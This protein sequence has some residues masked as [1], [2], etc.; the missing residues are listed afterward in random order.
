MRVPSALLAF[1]LVIGSLSAREALRREFARPPDSARPWVFAY[2]MDGNVTKEGITAD[3]EA[4]KSGGIGGLTFFDCAL[5]NPKGPHRF[6]SETWHE[7]FQHLM[8]EAA[9]LG[10]EVTL[11]NAAGWAGSGGPWVKPE[12]A[13]QKV[14]IHEQVVEGPRRLSS[15]LPK[16]GGVRHGFYR[17]IAVLA[18]P[19][20]DGA[21]TRR[22]E[23]FD[24]TKSFSGNRDFATVVPWPRHI[25]ARAE[26]PALP[27]GQFVEAGKMVD[28]TGRL[29]SDGTLAWEVP[30]G[31]WLVFRVGCTVTNGENRAAQPEGVGM[32]ANKLSRPAI[33]AHF[34]AMVGEL[35]RRSGSLAGTTLVGTHIDSWEA[36]SGNWTPLLREE[37]RR[38]RGYDLLPFLPTLNGVAVDSLEKSERF[39]W[40]FRETICELVLENYGDY[41]RQL[42]RE[43]G[44]RLSIQAYDGTADDLRYAGRADE[45]MGEFWQRPIYN[46]L[47]LGDLAEEMAS[48]AHVYGKPILSAEAFTTAREN[49]LEHPATLKPMADWAFCTGVNRICFSQW[50]VQPWPRLMPGVSFG[51]FGTAF[52]RSLTWWPQSR[53]WHDYVARC[54]HVLRQGRF[55]ADILFLSP[56]GA[57]QRFVAPVPLA[58]RGAIPDRPGYN[59]D[60]CPPELILQPE[61]RVVDGEVVLPSGMKYRLLVLPTYDVGGEPVL[62]LTHEDDYFYKPAPLP[63]VETMTPELLRR[64][65]QLVENGATVVGV[66]PLKSPSLRGY[67]ACDAEVTALADELWGRGN[68]PPS[69]ERKVGKGRV[70]WGRSPEEVLAADAV[71]L[72]FGPDAHLAGRVNYT[73]RRLDDGTDIYFVVNKQDRRAEGTVAFRTTH[74]DAEYWWPESGRVQPVPAMI[75]EAGVVRVPVALGANETVFVVFRPG[76]QND[77]AAPIVGVKRD[78]RQLW[79]AEPAAIPSPLE[80]HFT[81]AAWAKPNADLQ[82]SAKSEITMPRQVPGGWS[83]DGEKRT[84]AAAGY[85]TFTTLGQGRRGFSVGSNG[86]V[87]FQYG[88]SGEVQPLLAYAAPINRLTHVAV[89][90]RDR[91][92][93]LYLDGKLVLTGPANRFPDPIPFSWQDQRPFAGDLAAIHQ[94]EDLLAAAGEAPPPDP[95]RHAP[96]A[97]DLM[98]G[99]VWESGRYSIRR[100]TAGEVDTVVQL[101][102]AQS[103]EGGWQVA[104]DPARGGPGTVAL[105]RLIDWSRHADPGIRFYSGAGIYRR[106]FKPE[107]KFGAEGMR[108][109]LDLGEVAVIAA[110]TLNGRDLGV[111]WKPPFRVDL[112]DA[113]R[114]DDTNELEITVVNLWGNRLIGDEHLPQDSERN[115]A[116]M[117][118][119]WPQW[120]LDGKPSPAGRITFSARRPWTTEDPLV[121]SGLLGPVRL[122]GARQIP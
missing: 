20:A 66:R 3:L 57:P 67:P 14:I 70:V 35:V 97:I 107:R 10:L 105:E 36:G 116:G 30:A 25:P 40:D 56:E 94:F 112:T 92:P 58:R 103:L 114:R 101:P 89:T 7:H 22:I 110:V 6:L 15:P 104:F 78:G 9:R 18:F 83:Y 62:R 1:A 17:D 117:M 63:K 4:M 39:L 19:V 23:D 50:V 8:R 45:P 69:G 73:H 54:Q 74:R 106:S 90:Y 28:L 115:D 68:T 71:P 100:G 79:P 13:A 48:A 85:Q 88:T 55:V 16:P 119:S 93:R 95:A 86:V 82:F 24:S 41:F 44:L 99:L 12:Q 27:P 49:F 109:F 60:G 31:R 38:R 59:F 61:T 26:W 77:R 121:K 2:W 34:D 11:N 80:D 65:K 51:D 98:R 53:P 76:T 29:A 47:P 118:K 96:P 43:K 120:A 122:V 75:A 111:L 42:A 113:L 108:T 21:P 32:E 84:G 64:V 81:L 37:F 52:H 91:T 33:R 102:A 46:G 5:G 72:D 87:V